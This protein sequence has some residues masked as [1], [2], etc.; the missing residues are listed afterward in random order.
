MVTTALGYTPVPNTRNITING[1]TQDLSVDRTWTISAG[2]ASVSGS[3]AGISVS[4][5]TGAV[6]ISNTGVTSNVAGTGISVSGATGA[7]TITNTGVTSIVAGTA[8]TI[9]GAT[10]AVTINNAGVTSVNGSTGAV[11]GIITTSNYNSYSPTLTG[12]G[13]SGTWGISITGNSAT[14]STLATLGTGISYNTDRTVKISNGLAIYG[15]YN[16]G[17]N[18]PWTYDL[19][20]QFI[21]DS[22]GFE[23]SASWHAPSATLAFRTLRDCCDNWSS[24]VTMLSSSNYNSYSPTLTGGGASGTWSINITGSAGSASTATYATNTSKLYSTD[25]GYCYGCANP[26]YGYLTY[27]GSR[28]LFQVSPGTPAAVR[29]AYSDLS[30]QVSINYNNDSNSTYQMLWGSGNSVYGTAGVYVNPSSDYVYANSFNAGDWFR[31]SGN[32]G[33]YNSTYAVGI[34]ATDSTWV[35]TY[36]NAQ[37][38]SSTI[39]EAGGSVRAPIFY[40]SDNTAYYANFADTG[41]SI[42]IAGSI[43]AATYNKPGLLLNASGSTSSGAAFGMQQITSEGW[44]GIFVDYEPYTGWGLYHD[45]PANYFLITSETSTGSFGGGFT[46]PSRVSGNR[47]AYVKH[48]LDQNNGDFIAGGNIYMTGGTLVA[49]QSWVN[50]QGFTTGGPFVPVSGGV[51][52]TGSY[53]LNDNKLYL[54]TNGDNNHYLWNAGDDWEELNAYE[55]TGFRITSVGGSVGVLYVYGSSNGG[56]TYSPY[57][58][59]A[60]IFYDS[61]DTTYYLDPHSTGTSFRGRGEILLGPNTSGR[62]TRLGGNGGSTDEATLSASNGNLHIDC[63]G[64]FGLYLNYY[65]TNTIYLGNAGYTITSNGSYYNG[66]SAVANSV[67]WGNVTSKPSLIMYYQG[68]TLDANTMDGNSSGFTYSNNAPFTGPVIRISETGYSLWFNAAYAGGGTQLAF[69][70][71]NGDSATLN[72]WRTILHD[73]NYNSYSPTLTG[74][75]AS[76]TWGINITGNAGYASSA[77]N[78]DTVD[79]FHAVVAGNANT[80]PTRDG[81]GYFAPNNWTQLNGTYGLYSPT[82]AAHFYPNNGTYGS[83]KVEGSRNGWQG[84]EFASGSNGAVVVMIS[85]GSNESGFHN[86]AHGW[87]IFWSGGALYSGRNTYGGNHSRVLQEDTWINS[88]YFGSDGY[89]YGVRFSDSNDS[90]YFLDPN[91][92]SELNSITTG[93]RA[94]WGEPRIWTN[95]QAYASDQGYWTGTNGWG[96]SEG[97]WA[98]AWKGGFSGWDIWGTNT[99]HPQ[100]SGYIHAQGIVSGQHYATSDGSSAYGW[101]MVGAGDATANRYWLRGKWG[102]GISGWVEM[103]TSGNIGS[104]NVNYATTA[105]TASFA[106]NSGNTNSVSNATGGSYTWTGQQY[107][108]SN[109]GGYCG[110][111]SGPPLQAYSTSN[112]SAFFSFHKSG[113]YAVNMGLDADSV[114]RIGGWS[115]AAN[116]W[117][118][119]MSGNMTVAGDVTAYSDARVK[120]NVETVEDALDKVLNLRG[121]YYNRTDSDDKRRKVGVIAQEILEV[122]PE[123][124]GQDNDGMYNVSYGNIVGVLIEAIKEQQKQIDELKARLD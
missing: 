24:W 98:N 16:G 94:R 118:L 119:D 1:V 106:S 96:T 37:F 29:V 14:V 120:E 57:S 91:G 25:A 71:R 41:T 40:D 17:A 122:I 55:G 2:V 83:W 75:G 108:Q 93:T 104:Q 61:E 95:R 45:N 4:P 107:F 70:T 7:V 23:F 116:R 56:Y 90:S 32:S 11:T 78:A 88:K 89:I 68:F 84:L 97:N 69:R 34:Y 53:G 100:G 30:G 85:N 20:A 43:N 33:W 67:A 111:L 117:Q 21:R 112:N 39:I 49:T 113:Q 115:A 105:G 123:V 121:V 101:M 114:L 35:R 52:M 74:G 110:S 44:S 63:K 77:G 92:T 9:S 50:S 76:G 54:R 124:V 72:P 13:A 81:N 10:G 31:S 73:A 47:T 62:Y 51:N 15:A 6:V 8:I 26:Y 36:N 99:D 102:S 18:S 46:V 60:P 19:A 3:G 80:I 58:F 22:R 66:T 12:T 59:R 87:Q 103:I 27:D 42:N 82:N 79:G 5:T 65:S 86:N 109:L 38:Y 28:W 48:R 64:G